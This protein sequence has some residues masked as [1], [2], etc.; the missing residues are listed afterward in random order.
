MTAPPGMRY[1][2][3]TLVLAAGIAACGAGDR[4]DPFALCGNGI[5]DKGE[6]CDDGDA[7]SDTGV[8]LTTCRTAV[9]GD[10]FVDVGMEQCDQNNLR[11]QSCASLGF[12][13]GT[14]SCSAACTFDTSS[15]SPVR[16]TTPTAVRT[17]TPT[18]NRLE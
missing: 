8:C 1:F 5:L 14:L 9:C 16:P 3:A 2:L 7:N 11:F 4:S 10:G 13:G 6:Q 17:A 18:P 15:C 12:P